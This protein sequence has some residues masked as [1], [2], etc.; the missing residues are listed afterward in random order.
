MS[1]FDDDFAAHGLP[2]LLTEF[3]SPVTYKQEGEDDVSIDKALLG[4]IITTDERIASG[5]AKVRTRIVTIPKTDVASVDPDAEIEIAGETW[6][7]DDIEGETSFAT[8]CRCVIK[9]KTESVGKN[10]YDGR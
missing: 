5:Y 9:E 3:G 4:E 2:D 10:Y 7:I 6:Q 1:N 8:E